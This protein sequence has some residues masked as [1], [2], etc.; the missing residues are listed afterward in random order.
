MDET[1]SEVLSVGD[2]ESFCQK[3]GSMLNL[4]LHIEQLESEGG[5]SQLIFKFHPFHHIALN[6]YTTLASAFRIHSTSSDLLA[7]HSEIDE[8]QLKALDMSRTSA[9]YS[10]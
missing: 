10:L 3:L 2:P 7:F 5:E 8:C 6:A 4:G 9:A 1:K